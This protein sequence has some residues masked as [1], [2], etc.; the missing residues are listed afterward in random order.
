MDELWH[1]TGEIINGQPPTTHIFP[2][3]ACPA[4]SS[5]QAGHRKVKQP[6]LLLLLLP[7]CNCRCS[8]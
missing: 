7:S 4:W 8:K 3:Q 6:V 1:Q 2:Y 5:A